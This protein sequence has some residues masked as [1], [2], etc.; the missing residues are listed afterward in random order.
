MSSLVIIILIVFFLHCFFNLF[1]LNFIPQYLFDLEYC[2]FIF[3]G[4]SLMGSPRFHNP[5]YRFEELARV[6]FHIFLK[7]FL[8]KIFAVIFFAFLFT[9]SSKIY[10]LGQVFDLLT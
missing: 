1:F 5:S 2:F 10:V 3:L 9:G 4:L 7:H 8:K 6:D